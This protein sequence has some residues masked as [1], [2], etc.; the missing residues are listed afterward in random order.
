MKQLFAM[1]VPILPGKTPQWKKFISEL[2]GKRFA[3]FSESRKKLN[4]HER[5]FFQSTPQ[6]DFVVVTLEGKDPQT[7]FKNFAAGNDE[8]SKW[9]NAQ[10][11]EIHGMDLKNPPPGP[12]PE[13]VIDSLEEVLQH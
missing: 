9:F 2:N 6:G 1:A 5:A 13:L 3:E 12:L 7:A 4:V 8:F 10:V 11:K